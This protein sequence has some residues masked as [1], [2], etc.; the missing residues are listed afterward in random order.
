MATNTSTKKE[1]TELVP[2]PFRTHAVA[3]T[4][5][6][7][8]LI[9]FLIPENERYVTVYLAYLISLQPLLHIDNKVIHF[10]IPQSTIQ[11]FLYNPNND[12]SVDFNSAGNTATIGLPVLNKVVIFKIATNSSNFIPWKIVKNQTDIVLPQHHGFGR[13]VAWIDD[14]TIAILI[15]SV[16]DRPWSISEIW[17]FAIDKSFNVPFFVFPNN[18]QILLMPS[19]PLFLQMISWSGNLLILTDQFELLFLQKQPVGFCPQWN[20][21]HNQHLHVFEASPCVPGSYKN[22]SDFGPCTICPSE[23]KNQGNKPST[24]CDPCT[25]TSFCPPGSVGNLFLGNYSSYTQTYLYPD[26]PDMTN[27]DDILMQNIFNIEDN[28]QCLVMSP[29]FWSI[30]VMI[31]CFIV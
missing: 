15:L 27:Y 10:C 13:S 7:A 12:R 16:S 17:I 3:L 21:N 28:R 29:L 2:L 11:S 6:Y 1:L 18:Q 4:D 14:K 30:I 25:S 8:V 24:K 26:S 22:T 23:T 20:K 9:G 19:P 31:L 5:S